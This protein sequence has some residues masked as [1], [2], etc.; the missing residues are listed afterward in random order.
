MRVFVACAW[1]STYVTTC[2]SIAFSVDIRKRIKTVVW[3][4]ID[5]CLFDDMKNQ[6]II[7]YL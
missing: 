2:N 5:G 4:P 7:I 1:S 6:Y 3:S